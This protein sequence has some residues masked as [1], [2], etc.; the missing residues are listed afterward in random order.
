MQSEPTE[1]GTKGSTEAGRAISDADIV[2]YLSGNPEF[3]VENKE[4]LVGLKVPHESGSAIS[5]VEK[6]VSVLRSRCSHLE[7]SLR[8]LI[9][10]A[11]HNENLHQRLHALIQDIITAP[12][13]AEIVSL[14]QSSLRENF[15][16][17]NVHIML[18]APAPK[19]T[20][21]ARSSRK[22]ADKSAAVVEGAVTTK[23]PVKAA[24][25]SRPAKL[26][27][28]EGATVVRHTD[29]RIKHFSDVFDSGETVCGMP[30]TEQLVAILGKHYSE[31]ASAAIIPLQFER[32]LGLIMLTS[33]DEARFSST[34]GVMFLNQMGDLL[35]RRIHSYGMEQLVVGK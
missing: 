11:R 21:T 18:I 17:E 29:K 7:N 16:A 2:K 19:R 31:V 28:V 23:S 10:V 15:S 27:E 35:S 1:I 13:M 4:I 26:L 9:A 34:K 20:K 14:T 25:R 5:L 3:F 33:R 8:D 22:S 30:D 6:Q 32:K 12:S 24:I